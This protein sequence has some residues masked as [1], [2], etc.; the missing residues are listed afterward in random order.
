MAMGPVLERLNDEMLDPIIRRTYSILERA[1]LIPTPPPELE[2]QPIVVEYISIMAQAMKLQGVVGVERLVGFIGGIS[3]QRPDALDKLNTDEV[4]D[5][6]A[7]MVG[8]PPNLV[9]DS[10]TVGKIRDARQKQ[11]AQ[12]QQMAQLQQSALTAKVMADTQT[13]SPS[14]LQTM[15]GAAQQAGPLLSQG[16]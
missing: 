15:A 8:V 7:D 14:M 2:K 10:E 6:Y 4:I 13:S 5:A 12:A 3:A 1:G 9:N 16:A 11:E